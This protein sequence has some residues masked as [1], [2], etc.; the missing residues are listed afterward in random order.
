[1]L[2][3]DQIK[4]ENLKPQ[5]LGEIL[6]EAKKAYYT[7]GKP[8]MDDHTY[9]T[10]ENILRQKNPHHRLFSKVGTPNFETG[11]EKKTHHHPMYSQ[12]KV[13]NFT[14][15][16]HY[17]E[18]KQ[19]AGKFN[20]N[21]LSF[22]AQPKCDGL[23]LEITYLQGKLV[24]AITRGDGQTGDLVTQNVV[25]MQNFK[26]LLPAP[27]SGSIRCEIVVTKKDFEMLNTL[28]GQDKTSLSSS[29]S[30]Q[31]TFYSNPR[32][33]AS[34]ITQRLDGKYSHLCTLVPV[35]LVEN[36]QNI[37]NEI[38]KI[39]KIESLGLIPVET[40][41]CTN[42]DQIEELYNKFLSTSRQTYLFDI[43]G[44]VIKIN[45]LR[46]AALL[47]TNNNRPKYQVAY[48]FPADTN[49]TTI[50]SVDW[51]VGPMG[52]ITPVANIEPIQVSGAI[53]TFASLANHH[54][55]KEKNIQIGDIVKVSRRGDV[56]PHIDSVITK[57][58]SGFVAPPANCPSCQTKLIQQNKF[59]ICPNSS[60][61][62]EQIIGGL[63]LFCDSLDIK[64]LSFQTI[65][66]LYQAGLIKTPG[67]FYHLTVHD[68][69]P[70]E[71]LGPKSAANIVHQIQQ[72]RNLSLKELYSSAIIPHFS[73]ARIQQ[74]IQAGFDT[75][76]KIQNLTVDQLV[77]LKGFQPVLAGKII[78]GL[79]LRRS[80]IKSIT[81]NCTLSS[82]K[83]T[84]HAPLASLNFVITG[85]LSQPRSKYQQKIES[86]GGKLCSGVTKNTSYLITSKKDTQ[87]TKYATAL[88]LGVK[89]ITE[90]EFI[91]LCQPPSSP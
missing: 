77:P 32:N 47:G 73:R 25:Q 82:E 61:C 37:E 83:S 19:T 56:I 67:D 31:I 70:L 2:T 44:L 62:Q 23:S 88:K 18:L 30:N 90:E 13:S 51:Q 35:D 49:Q 34:G 66:K 24:D 58:N 69:A 16:V 22:L 8:I 42:F 71:N 84:R 29:N 87:G 41:L 80:W 50:L 85:Q 3:L 72:K 45:Q 12:N 28:V 63:R 76:E 60:S 5:E 65:K 11:F 1:M 68:I 54:L 33:A 4:P 55:I 14:D 86:L 21:E 59:L 17:F 27:F 36:N 40:H 75:P 7:T 43:D 48:K 89:I 53:I 81:E 91:R 9:D 64:G 52:T 79:A 38:D 57:V 46:F 26:A 10:L 78:N 15:L 74:V 6:I 39:K 20:L